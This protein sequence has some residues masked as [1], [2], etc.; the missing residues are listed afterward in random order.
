MDV[1]Y[2]DEKDMDDDDKKKVKKKEKKKKEK[3]KIKEKRAW[4]DRTNAFHRVIQTRCASSTLVSDVQLLLQYVRQYAYR[5]CNDRHSLRELLC[6]SRNEE[7]H[8]VA[9]VI[10]EYVV[11]KHVKSE[12]KALIAP[13][14]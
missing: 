8:T 12:L 9:Q 6:E 2:K 1:T 13:Y 11:S 14:L 10:D 7:G 5:R 3:G 4:Y